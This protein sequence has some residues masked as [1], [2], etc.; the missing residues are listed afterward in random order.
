ME[1]SANGAEEACR[2]R[3]QRCDQLSI[4]FLLGDF[5]FN[6]KFR[7]WKTNCMPSTNASQNWKMKVTG[8]MQ[9]KC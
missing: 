2:V 7:N 8:V 4:N 1:W 3:A 9:W 5:R 6:M